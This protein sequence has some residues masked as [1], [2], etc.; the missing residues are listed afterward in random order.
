MYPFMLAS[1]APHAHSPV[2]TVLPKVANRCCRFLP[3]LP[4]ITRNV[5]LP[6]RDTRLEFRLQAGSPLTKKAKS[7]KNGNVDHPSQLSPSFSMILRCLRTS[8]LVLAPL[9]SSVCLRVLCGRSR[10]PPP[11]QRL[12]QRAGAIAAQVQ[13]YVQVA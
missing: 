6:D 7:G 9:P 10:L 8:V 2:A 5:K 13:R 12:V 3:L 4:P 1:C 11:Q